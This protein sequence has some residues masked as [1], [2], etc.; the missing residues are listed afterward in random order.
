MYFKAA[1]DNLAI[2]S[3]SEKGYL[4]VVNFLLAKKMERP[5]LYW[6]VSRG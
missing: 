2:K 5:D 6:E 1:E 4:E 3:A